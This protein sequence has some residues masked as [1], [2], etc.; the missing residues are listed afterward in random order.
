GGIVGPWLRE[1]ATSGDVAC[2]DRLAGSRRRLLLDASR[3]RR[4]RLPAKRMGRLRYNSLHAVGLL[5]PSGAGNARH[6]GLPL[7]APNAPT[8]FPHTLPD[9]VG[10]VR[11]GAD[12]GLDN[13]HRRV[14]APAPQRPADGLDAAAVSAYRRRCRHAARGAGLDLRETP[15]RLGPVGG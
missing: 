10:V 14:P 6:P 5:S 15:G 12:D 13:V 8:I 1:I 4:L 3:S 9:R 11:G 2:D 7:A